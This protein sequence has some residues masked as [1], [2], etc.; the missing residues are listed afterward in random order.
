MAPNELE[1]QADLV[2]EQAGLIKSLEA[3]LASQADL[4]KFQEAQLK[5]KERE[6]DSN[7]DSNLN[8]WQQCEGEASN[9][10]R[11][12]SQCKRNWCGGSFP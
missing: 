10:D 6:V 11:E 3:Q 7:L 12:L 8:K 5:A 2:E 4:I 9:K 1:E